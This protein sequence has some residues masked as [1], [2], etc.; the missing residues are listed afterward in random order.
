MVNLRGSN[1]LLNFCVEILA[2]WRLCRL[3]MREDCPYEIC[4]KF[5][6]WIGISYNERNEPL[7]SNE[8]AQ[9]FLCIYCLSVW[10]GFFMAKGNIKR[11]LA[12]SAGAIIVEKWMNK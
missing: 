7:A 11:G 4:V 2:T 12:I 10:V 9:L 5:R 1:N 8:F 3:L 6:D